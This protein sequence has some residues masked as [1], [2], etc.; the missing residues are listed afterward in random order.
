MTDSTSIDTPTLPSKA[1]KPLYTRPKCIVSCIA[2]IAFLILIFQ[3]WNSVSINLF[4]MTDRQVPAALLYIGF[5]LVGFVVGW[6]VR[7]P[8]HSSSKES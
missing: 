4:F 1:K 2:A 3:N 8:K 5:S 7:R 6:L